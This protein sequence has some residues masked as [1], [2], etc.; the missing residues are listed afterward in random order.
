MTVDHDTVVYTERT[1]Q[2]AD[3]ER[4][5]RSWE[6]KNAPQSSAGTF[7]LGLIHGLGDHGGRLDGLG[8]WFARRGVAVYCF[9]QFGHGKSPGPRVVIP[10]YDFLLQDID[11]FLARLSAEH[12][13]AKVGIYGQSMGG[14]LVLNHQLRDYSRPAFVIA[15]SPMLRAKRPPHPAMMVVL[16]VLSR[17]MPN[18]R[19]SSP[20]DPANLSRDPDAQQAFEQDPLIQKRISLRLGRELIDSGQ[21]A[22]ENSSQLQIPTLI[23]HGDADEVTCHQASLEFAERSEGRADIKIW[24]EGVHDLHHDIVREQYLQMLLDWAGRQVDPKQ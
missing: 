6:C 3:G 14:N 8:R 2:L 19:L 18:H 11:A 1:W 5:V 22:I 15:G 16:R 4:F 23:T 7:V 13:D 21:W 9:D 24:P 10:S 20:V 12:P 17:L